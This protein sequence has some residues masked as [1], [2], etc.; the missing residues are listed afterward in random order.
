M[1]TH[2]MY[3][4][5]TQGSRLTVCSVCGAAVPTG[6]QGRHKRWHRELADVASSAAAAER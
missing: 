6:T 2:V 4:N 1:R 5:V 3:T